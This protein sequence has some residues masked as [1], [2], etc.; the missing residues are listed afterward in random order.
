[1]DDDYYHTVWI[2]DYVNYAWYKRVIPQNITT[3]CI[4]KLNVLSA[5]D[6]GKIYIEDYGTTFDGKAIKFMW[7]SPFLSLG[8]VLHRKLIDE[9]YFVLD[10]IHDNKFKFS[11]YKD[12]DSEYKD[13]IELIY[14]KHFNH[15]M[16]SGDDTP[17]EKN[18]AGMMKNRKL[19]FGL[20]QQMQW[21]KLKYAA[22]IILFSFALKVMISLIT[23]LLIGLQFREIY[24]DD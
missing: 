20:L 15:F 13:D 4:Y 19:R 23:V 22:V 7:K 9:F 21:R 16:W 1:M 17:D 14:C 24:N 18:I 11:I 10:D 12:Y 6:S 2:N 3:A 8:N 5:D